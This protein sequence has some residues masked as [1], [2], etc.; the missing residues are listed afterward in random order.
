M[1]EVDRAQQDLDEQQG[2]LDRLPADLVRQFSEMA[3]M[4]PETESDSGASIIEAIL[5]AVDVHDL[6]SPWDTKDPDALVGQW[7]IITEASRSMS[8][9]KESLGVFLVITAVQEDTGEEIVFTSGSMG[10]VA[11]VVKAYAADMLPLRAKLVR[12]DKPT[13]NGYWPQHLVVHQNQ[14]GK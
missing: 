6:D 2:L 9:Y 11:Q 4:L 7:L 14:P 5:G 3:M 8:T 1:T 10:V 12:A 13:A